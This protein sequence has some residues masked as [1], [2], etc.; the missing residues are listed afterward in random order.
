MKAL[1]A[2]PKIFFCTWEAGWSTLDQLQKGT[3]LLL[4]D[5]AFIK[6]VRSPWTT[7]FSTLKD[8]IV[9]GDAL[10]FVWCFVGKSM[11]VWDTLLSWKGFGVGKKREKV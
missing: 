4:I 10:L 8:K 1:C 5:A 9:V 3:F 2:R 6:R 11:F 7:S